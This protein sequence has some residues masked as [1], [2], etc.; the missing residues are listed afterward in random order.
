MYA[1]IDLGSNSFH[2]LIARWHNGRHQI[3]ERFSEKVQLGEGLS[4][5]GYIST[6]AFDRGLLCLNT[7]RHAIDRYPINHLWCVGT[8]ALRIAANAGEFL[9]A[10]AALGIHVDIVTGH[11]EAALVYAG[12]LSALPASEQVRL[13][14]DIGGGST[15]VVVGSGQQVLQSHSLSVGC[16][17]WR[18]RWFRRASSDQ[19]AGKAII[20]RHLLE[21]QEEAREIFSGIACSL[22]K[23][24]WSNAY[25]SSG[26]AKMLCAVSAQH[27]SKGVKSGV[28]LDQ[29][30]GMKNDLLSLGSEAAFVMAGLKS[31]R[32]DLMLSGWAVLSGFMLA[33]N[34]TDI[35]YSPAALREGM[36]H[37]MVQ[38]AAIGGSP[39]HVLRG[40]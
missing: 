40:N 26:T 34:V 25:A 16:V 20:E 37:Y 36:L 5:G 35:T 38:A 6:A 30:L 11:E 32:R 23:I 19:F 2:L 15:E 14:L 22:A 27:S 39:L 3:V 1:C 8:N 18:D 24:P 29:L 10:A 17:T 13:I 31:S 9:R 7:F 28:S 4:N 12:V 33:N 21:A